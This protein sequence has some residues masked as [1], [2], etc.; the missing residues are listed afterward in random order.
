M[1]AG[2]VEC[3]VTKRNTLLVSRVA[4]ACE[5]STR[6]KLPVDIDHNI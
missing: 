1:I 3:E 5:E 6:T 2:K 4:D